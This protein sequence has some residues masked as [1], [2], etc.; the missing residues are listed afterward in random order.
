MTEHPPERHAGDAIARRTDLPDGRVLEVRAAGEADIDGLQRM[1]DALPFNDRYLRFFT[2]FK[3]QRQFF[4]HMLDVGSHGGCV[5]VAIVHDGDDEIVGDAWYS[6]LS[7]GDGELAIMVA[8]AWRGWLGPYLLDALLE[9]AATR[10]VKNLQ[11]EFLV[12]NTGMFALARSRGYVTVDNDDPGTM[13]VAIPTSGHAPSWPDGS[14]E[15]V[16]VLVETPTGR[17]TAPRDMRDEP[18]QVRACPGPRRGPDSCPALRGE[19]C[20]LARDADMIV[21]ALPD[22]DPSRDPLIQAHRSL[23][24]GVQLC[25]ELG[26]QP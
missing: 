7:D 4:E 9:T 5:L 21:M 23:H 15:R 8:P 25:I 16:R 24:S 19:Q 6:L 20:P 18:L 11:A 10:G 2:A 26:E 1:Y 13:R 17:W 22:D 14:D 12:H 3:P